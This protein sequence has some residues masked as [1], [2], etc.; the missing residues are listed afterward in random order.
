M[1]DSKAVCPQC[2]KDVIF[3]KQGN[4]RQCPECGF[5]YRLSPPP[6]PNG[7][8]REPNV[9]LEFAGLILKVVL[10]MAAVAAIGIAILFAGCAVIL[11]GHH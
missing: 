2:Q 5:Q 6:I 1:N 4:F 3:V 8:E 9:F 10:Y 7:K 11:M